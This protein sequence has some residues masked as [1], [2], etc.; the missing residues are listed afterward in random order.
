MKFVLNL[1][2]L[3]IAMVS[4]SNHAEAAV[5]TPTKPKSFAVSTIKPNSVT[6]KWTPAGTYS[7]FQIET[8]QNSQFT[9]GKSVQRLGKVKAYTVSGLKA[10]TTYYFRLKALNG[11]KSSKYTKTLAAKTQALP[12]PTPTPTPTP[13]S[14]SGAVSAVIEASRL[15]GPAPLAVQF[16]ATAS[17]ATGVTLP[18]HQLDYDFYFGDDRG[19][20]WAH[21][22]KPKNRQSG[23]ALAAHV[24]DVPGQYTVV[25]RVSNPAT[26]QFADASVVVNVTDPSLAF[27]GSNTTCVSN[28]GDFSGCPAGALQQTTLPRTYA[29]QRVLLKRGE[30]F[31]AVSLNGSDDNV[32]VGAFGSG[33]K[34]IV[35]RVYLGGNGNV[36]AWPDEV[37]LMDLNITNGFSV[38]VTGS[39]LLLYRCDMLHR[40]REKI[41]VG[42][43]LVYY[44]TN[45]TL[46]AHQYYWPREIFLVENNAFGDT[47]ND[48]L[49]QLIAMGFFTKSAMLGNNF[50][51][52][53]EHT[54]R[55]WAGYKMI[56]AHNDLGGEHYANGGAGIRHA[57]K[58]HASGTSSFNE[59]VGV[60]GLGIASRYLVTADNHF[61][62]P[63]NPGSWTVSFGP[64]NSDQG[65]VQGL[66]DIIMERDVFR[67]GPYTT[68]D[69]HNVARRVTVRDETVDNGARLLLDQVS[70]QSW[71]GDR[72]MEPWIGPYFGMPN[73]Y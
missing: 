22:G 13:P 45:G 49:P 2:T 69:I 3:V 18:F 35:D 50:N 4:A 10:S 67:R 25:V 39:R 32:I 54:V 1:A 38:A 14:S 57:L 15:S 46:P 56:L 9:A 27:P 24:F 11:S 8:A 71:R 47:N 17:T 19:L 37:I 43:A 62:S 73:N 20:N 28:S 12:T 44:V 53:T 48:N 30:T 33:A 68:L 34:P 23:A 29:G 55:I 36:A 26:G 31:A 70:P 60:S 7:G 6:L 52:S 21:S 72:N 5:K 64:E 65:T 16:D 61:G 66:E 51:G 58:F 42:T 40:D 59:N 63:Y 41:D